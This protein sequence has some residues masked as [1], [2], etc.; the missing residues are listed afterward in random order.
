MR[1]GGRFLTN[2]VVLRAVN[3]TVDHEGVV[4]AEG[5]GWSPGKGPGAGIPSADGKSGP[6]GSHGGLGGQGTNAKHAGLGNDNVLS[7]S[8][9][10]SGGSKSSSAKVC[11]KKSAI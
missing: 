6:G 10:G 4:D 11:W 2:K 9:Y 7:P 1:G 3:I 8:Q 5:R